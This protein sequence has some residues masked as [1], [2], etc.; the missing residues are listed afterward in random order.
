MII[1]SFTL[2][3][4]VDTSQDWDMALIITIDEETVVVVVIA[5]VVMEVVDAE[6]VGVVAVGVVA[7]DAAADTNCYILIVI[8]KILNLL[9]N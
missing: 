5:A 9:R 6:V 2:Q 1:P 8:L 4:R 7:V 3:Q